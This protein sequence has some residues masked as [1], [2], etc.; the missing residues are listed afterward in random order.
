MKQQQSMQPGVR[1]FVLPA[2]LLLP[3]HLLPI[4]HPPAPCKGS[5]SRLL[6]SEARLGAAQPPPT[7]PV[8][9]DNVEFVIFVRAKKFPQWYPLS[10]VKGGSAANALVKA[11]KSELGKKLSGNTLVRNIGTVRS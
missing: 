9:P 4:L 8:D 10:V 7:P 2:D 5:Y 3:P 1:L 6:L 11:M